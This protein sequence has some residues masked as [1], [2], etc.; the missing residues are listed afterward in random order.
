MM[1]AYGQSRDEVRDGAPLRI[2]MIIHGLIKAS[3]WWRYSQ[4]PKA[5]FDPFRRRFLS[6]IKAEKGHWL[7]QR[8]ERPACYSCCRHGQAIALQGTT[9]KARDSRPVLAVPP[10]AM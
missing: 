1:Q 10:A 3:V 7:N 4:Y 9:K 8:S 5:R 2:S 6:I